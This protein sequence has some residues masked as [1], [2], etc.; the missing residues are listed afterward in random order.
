[1]LPLHPLTVLPW[2][3][4]AIGALAVSIDRL[5]FWLFGHFN[6]GIT[7]RWTMVAH[8]T[9]HGG[10][11]KCDSTGH[12]NRN[13]F[14]IGSTIRRAADWFEWMLPEVCRCDYGSAQ[15][16]LFMGCLCLV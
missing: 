3:M 7:A 11:D 8:H 6:S 2:A 14:A 10:Y 16:L 1:M 13:R 15:K 5:L 4:L 12:Y 9:C